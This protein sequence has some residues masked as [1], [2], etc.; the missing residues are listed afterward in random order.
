M[1]NYNTF[2]AAIDP[3]Q[4]IDSKTD[5]N[6]HNTSKRNGEHWHPYIDQTWTSQ[7]LSFW[8]QSFVG[9]WICIVVAIAV[10]ACQKTRMESILMHSIRWHTICQYDRLWDMWFSDYAM[11][12]TQSG[13][14]TMVK[15]MA[16]STN[17]SNVNSNEL[18][19]GGLA[20][21]A[22]HNKNSNSVTQ[23]QL[24]WYRWWSWMATATRCRE[25]NIFAQ[26][27]TIGA[28]E[29]QKGSENVVDEADIVTQEG[30]DPTA[31]TRQP[32]S[33]RRR[34]GRWCK[35]SNNNVK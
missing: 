32:Q 34:Q 35:R 26:V 17:G 4:S 25:N 20:M 9:Q 18:T 14:V 21:L 6:A 23:R 7:P 33:W 2:V 19:H 30:N 24:Q 5:L 28:M 8:R 16:E 10:K 12:Y 11:K 31:I 3:L 27:A 29:T 22:K 15:R 1:Q 13:R